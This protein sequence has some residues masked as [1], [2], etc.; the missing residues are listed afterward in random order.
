MQVIKVASAGVAK[1]QS[2]PLPQIRPG[3]VLVRVAYVS[4]NPTDWKHVD[5]LPSFGATVGCDYSG[6]VEEVGSMVKTPWK[7]G[8]RIAGFTHGVNAVEQEDGCFAEFCV[9]KGDCQMGVPNNVSL[10][11]AATLG[12]GVTT[13]GQALYQSLK[14]PLPPNPSELSL[15]I[16]V[17]GG[18]TATGAL[19]IQYAKLSGPRVVTICSAANFA[20][21]EALGAD[22]AFT[23]DDADCGAQVR[24]YTDNNLIHAFDCISEGSSAQICCDA[25]SVRGGYISYLLPTET[26]RRDVFGH[27]TLA[28]TFKG[29]PFLFGDVTYPASSEDHE[30]AQFFWQTSTRL[31]V[32]RRLKAHRYEVRSGGLQGVLEGLADLKKGTVRGKKLVYKVGEIGLE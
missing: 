11:E 3:Y 27:H 23:Y 15:W 2:A 13:V 7:K 19:A 18:N 26:P 9:A 10:E 4:L 12:V 6:T 31:F 22:K 21:A 20:Y 28:Y 29:E 32:D 14:L 30:F 24:S 1:L 5:F 25:I 8:D 17:Y 16:L